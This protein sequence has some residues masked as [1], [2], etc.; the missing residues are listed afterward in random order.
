M[1]LDFQL[2]WDFGFICLYTGIL[3][4]FKVLFWIFNCTWILDLFDL[5]GVSNCDHYWLFSR[6]IKNKKKIYVW[7]VVF[8]DIFLTFR[9]PH[10]N[11][12]K[13]YVWFVVF[14]HQYHTNSLPPPMT[15]LTYNKCDLEHV[16]LFLIFFRCHYYTQIAL[17]YRPLFRIFRHFNNLV[18]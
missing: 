8:L 17:Y 9:K 1:V 13:F 2:Y 16:P 18:F 6:P 7:F 14:L 5:W 3:D 10:E 11:K 15:F 12:K 4:L